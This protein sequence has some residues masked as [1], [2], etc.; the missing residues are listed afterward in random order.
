[1]TDEEIAVA[2]AAVGTSALA[3]RATVVYRCSRGCVMLCVLTVDGRRF[4]H[5][6]RYRLSPAINERETVAA[7][8][9]KHT[10]DGERRWQAEA[11]ARTLAAGELSI[12]CDHH[13]AKL[14][15]DQIDSD[16]RTATRQPTEIRV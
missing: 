13:R 9:A 16:C 5:Q 14:D 12:E 15:V 3:K 11:F 8:R 4:I 10:V 1:M 7:A 2:L 6:P